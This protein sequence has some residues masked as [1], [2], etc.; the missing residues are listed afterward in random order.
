L[1]DNKEL[2]HP[3][4]TQ[5]SCNTAQTKDLSQE[6]PLSDTPIES[7]QNPLQSAVTEKSLYEALAVSETPLRGQELPKFAKS[8]VTDFGNPQNV[9]DDDRPLPQITPPELAK[10]PQKS[11]GSMWIEKHGRLAPPK[12]ASAT[13]AIAQNPTIGTANAAC[14]QVYQ[15]PQNQAVSAIE[16]RIGCLKAILETPILR[17]GKS[18]SEISRL[19]SE[20]EQL[21]RDRTRAI[22]TDE[23][24][25]NC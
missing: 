5:S 25:Q 2:W 3:E 24:L 10:P 20:L 11:N 15:P 16:S 21:E 7:T 14:L 19:Q 8:D 6:P 23:H 13:G 1:Y 9:T 17:R 18:P 4:F 12:T 22:A